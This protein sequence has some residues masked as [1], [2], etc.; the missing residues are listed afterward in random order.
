MNGT[1]LKPGPILKMNL[2]SPLQ[3]IV[4]FII[5][6]L[7]AG[8]MPKMAHA[9]PHPNACIDGY[10]WREAYPDDHVCV[11]PAVR[12][13][14]A[15]DNRLA[16]TRS[17]PQGGAYG[18]DTCKAGFVWREARPDDHVCV[19]PEVRT[20]AAHDNRE[21]AS[22]SLMPAAAKNGAPH[23]ARPVS[24][25]PP[26][27]TMEMESAPVTGQAR[28]FKLPEFPWP[29]PPDSTRLKIARDLLV[30]G[31]PQPSNGS[32]A[33]RM[34]Q[35]LAAN[36]YT[37]IGYYAVPDGFAMVT[38]IERIGPRAFPAAKQR[39]STQIDPVSLIP[40]NLNAYIKALR[41]KNGGSFRVIVFTFT[42][43]PF[44]TSDKVVP[45]EAAMAWVKK[46]ATALPAEL[47][48]QA[49]G[50]NTRCTALVYE[51]RISSLG[52]SLQES[53]EFNGAQHLS[54]AGILKTLKQKP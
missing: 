4:H 52:A 8:L 11:T 2:R 6:V 19:P 15:A 51:F 29:P 54:A 12:T 34:E 39:W 5:L 1:A 38:Q 36:G 9:A 41:G 13:Q 17:E 33:A 50:I 46:G 7:L 26:R 28:S 24:A 18:P 47:A 35:A 32:V 37:Q 53:S 20:Q 14:A 31:Q 3:C 42:P 40:F 43:T 16:A 48:A 49:Y 21:A 45:P 10:I 23:D 25:A 44:T 22:R 30:T 27:P